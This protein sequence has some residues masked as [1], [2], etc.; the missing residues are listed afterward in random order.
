MN[1]KLKF[2]QVDVFTS[3]PFMGNPVAVIFDADDFSE[4]EMQQIANWTKLSETTFVQSSMVGDY[5]YR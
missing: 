2:N 5:H 4:S 3:V 1:M